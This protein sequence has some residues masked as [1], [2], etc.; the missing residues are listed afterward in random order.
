MSRLV[1]YFSG[2][3]PSAV[4]TKLAITANQWP[5]GCDELAIYNFEIKEEHPDNQRFLRECE[6]WFGQKIITVGNDKYDRSVDNVIRKTRY[7]VGP[8]GARCTGEL[9]KTMRWEVGKPDDVIVMGYTKE[10]Q[11]RVDRLL[12]SEPLL[13]MWNILSERDLYR[14]DVMA[15]FERTG[16]DLPAMY[17]L[18]YRNNNCIGCVKGGAGYWNNIKIDFPERFAEMAKIERELGRTICKRE[19]VENGESKRDRIYLDELPSDLGNYPEERE[20]QCGIFCQMAEQDME[21]E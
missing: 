2:G 10:E 19:Y 6:E 20:F 11:E 17:K 4:A 13:Q 9:K 18:G 3:I 16:I 8:R 14:E 7:L 5:E 21:T 1:S 12:G 15:I